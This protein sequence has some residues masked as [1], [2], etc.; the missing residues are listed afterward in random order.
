MSS[1]IS[2]AS[3]GEKRFV[4]EPARVEDGRSER[5]E[6][7]R[8]ILE[9][10]YKGAMYPTLCERD[11]LA[12]QSANAST[13]F[14]EL[15]PSGVEKMLDSAHLDGAS[16]SVMYDLGMGLGRLIIQSFLQHPNLKKVIGVELCPSR[17]AVAFAALRELAKDPRYRFEQNSDGSRLRVIERSSLAENKEEKALSRSG[18]GGVSSSSKEE[19]KADTPAAWTAVLPKTTRYLELRCCD[20]F[21]CKDALEDAQIVVL[22]TAFPGSMYTKVAEFTAQFPKATRMMTYTALDC[23]YSYN[24]S[25]TGLSGSSSSDQRKMP[26]D[27]LTHDGYCQASFG[28]TFYFYRKQ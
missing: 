3:S 12:V 16:A 23:F 21:T 19:K 25:Y 7:V 18:S 5:K 2:P 24:S 11:T 10:I 6:T 1:L 8:E 20:L 27:V 4:L 15:T 13:A 14:G 26:W 22:E 28:A 9:R 17:A